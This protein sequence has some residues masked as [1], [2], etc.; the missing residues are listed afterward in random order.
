LIG[1]AF[2]RRSSSTRNLKPF[3]L[4][5]VSVS[6]GSSRVI[7]RD[8]PPH[9]PDFKNIRM[10]L[11]GLFLKYSESLLVANFV[12]SS[13]VSSFPEISEK[14]LEPV[15]RYLQICHLSIKVHWIRLLAGS[16]C[17]QITCGRVQILDKINSVL[18]YRR[19]FCEFHTILFSRTCE[20]R[21]VEVM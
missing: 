16:D 19:H 17:C 21:G 6:S 20:S 2:P 14:N 3:M 12:T 13:M 15:K 4:K 5:T 11:T 7:A 18:E 1:A 9:P 8:G 10:G